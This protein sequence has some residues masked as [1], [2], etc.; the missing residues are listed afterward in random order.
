MYSRLLINCRLLPNREKEY[1]SIRVRLGKSNENTYKSNTHESD[2][3]RIKAF[4]HLNSLNRTIYDFYS[5]TKVSKIMNK[6]SFKFG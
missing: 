6:K 2:I 3:S 4:I 5:V 1:I